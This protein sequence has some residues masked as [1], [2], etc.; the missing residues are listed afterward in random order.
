VGD[1]GIEN[2][3]NNFILNC[4]DLV[5]DEEL[6]EAF[7]GQFSLALQ[8]F[9]N[10]INNL[11]SSALILKDINSNLYATTSAYNRLVDIIKSILD[12]S[13]N[14]SIILITRQIPKQLQEED[15]IKL[16]PLD[17][18]QTKAYIKN[19]PQADEDS[20]KPEN[21]E[22]LIALTG[23][24]P[25]HI[26]RLIENLRVAT[27]D[28]LIESEIDTPITTIETEQIPKS[29]MQAIGSLT[30][31][32]DRYKLRSL[33][34][35]KILT[36]LANGE[37]VGN[38]KRFNSSE[39]IYIQNAN[40][41]EQLSLLEVISTSKFISELS[42]TS[43]TRQIKLL[44][45]PRQIRDYIATLITESERD[46]ILKN[47]CLL[48]FGPKWREG[49][50][51]KI[52]SS[53]FKED[54][55]YLNIDNCQFVVKNLLLNALKSDISYEIERAA[56]LSIN[57]C[58]LVFK[59]NDYKNSLNT[60]EDIYHLLKSTDLN[61][62]KAT[63]TKLYGES[64]RMNG[65]LNKAISILKEALTLDEGG[66]S[67]NEKNSIYVDLG[68]ALISVNKFDR[69]IEYAK[70]IEKTT[71]EKDVYTIQAKFIL[72]QCTLTGPSLISKLRTLES[73]AK[74]INSAQLVNT[75][76]LKIA[77][78]TPDN[79]EERSKRFSKVL[80]TDDDY[81]KIRAIIKKSLDTIN[82]KNA[83]ISQTDLY[84]LS[85]SYSYLYS[86]RLKSLFN[87]CHKALWSYC[88]KERRHA[89]LLNLFKHSSFIWRI[90]DEGDIE[91]DYLAK[92]VKNKS[93]NLNSLSLNKFNQTNID[94][95]S[96]RKLELESMI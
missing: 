26:D 62:Q 37:T 74:R 36:I 39:P 58:R 70:E 1:V 59:I 8:S 18:P 22:K 7:A 57:Y 38:L 88:I 31:S 30:D 34:L 83:S 16:F 82:D 93:I 33:K 21:F 43:E 32:T 63:I 49:D 40:E 61:Q 48:Y 27:F 3:K 78:L 92:L 51:K 71:T 86:Q 94:Y 54:H 75:I 12:Y 65:Q 14:T 72:A 56:V 23:G 19:L 4:E 89:E 69:A 95:V 90:S 91:K 79:N 5:S 85:Q 13:P 44:R 45:V 11:D 10:L 60:S 46:E 42:H 52:H 67:N 77:D 50:I 9:C 66:F 76:S 64:L 25:K 73:D 15:Y 87:D 35:L 41:L 47:A 6:L 81:N 68:L 17:T 84:I 80:S 55:S 24:L 2:N 28:E 53:T 20:I 96:R 29:L